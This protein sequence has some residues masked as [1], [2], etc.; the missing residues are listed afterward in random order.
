M[1]E[2]NFIQ[3]DNPAWFALTGPQHSFAIGAAHAKRFR[4]GI[5]PFAAY[6]HFAKD[7]IGD[8]NQYLHPGE[9]FFLI[10][11][12]PALPVNWTILKELPCVQMV[13]DRWPNKE[14]TS[15]TISEL[16]ATHRME[17]FEL[18]QKVQPGYYEPDTHLL[19]NYFGIRDGERLVAIAGERMQP[20]GLTEISAICTDPDYVGRKY[21]QHLI[22]HLCN[23]SRDKGTIPFLHVLETNERA[24]R[25]YEH[26]G[27]VKR[28]LISFWK[29]SCNAIDQ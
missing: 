6:D 8:L 3:L 17:M 21:A 25:L 19:G 10:G 15:I 29:I 22:T 14:E 12:L 9:I 5:L 27:F 7:K 23:L 18:I 20:D 11:E 24:I 28:R 2:G 16:N 26:M 1:S 13:L 4:H